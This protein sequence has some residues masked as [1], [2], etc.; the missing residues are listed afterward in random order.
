MND[1]MNSAWDINYHLSHVSDMSSVVLQLLPTFPAHKAGSSTPL[2][3]RKESENLKAIIESF[4][5]ELSE[6]KNHYHSQME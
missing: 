4:C 1:C 5:E 3:S 6:E 2:K